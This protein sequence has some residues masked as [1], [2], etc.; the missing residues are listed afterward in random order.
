MK[1]IFFYIVILLI[2]IQIPVDR[3]D[4]SDLEPIEAVGVQKENNQ[5]IIST[6]TE[7]S[8]RGS[9]VEQ[10]VKSMKEQCEK[11]VYLDTAKYL[12]VSGECVDVL[13][14]L[15]QYL[16]S[17]VKVGMWSGGDLAEF[18]QYMRSH[19]AGIKLKQCLPDT[20]LPQIPA[21]GQN[22]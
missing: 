9:T 20:R 18:S 6:D 8:G 3:I 1:K 21:V 7:R 15:S 19:H 11:I 2:A 17:S 16:K 12:L 14:D 5:Y 13:A 22:S 10:A 4:I